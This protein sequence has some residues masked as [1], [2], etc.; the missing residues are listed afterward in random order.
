VASRS[1]S[2]RVGEHA[3]QLGP[4]VNLGVDSFQRTVGAE[5]APV[6]AG[7][8]QVGEDVGLSVAQGPGHLGVAGLEQLQALGNRLL[9]GL[10]EG[11]NSGHG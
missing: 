1:K 9:G 8:G 11:I 10:L 2:G 6:L 7:E 5:R 4:S 3:H